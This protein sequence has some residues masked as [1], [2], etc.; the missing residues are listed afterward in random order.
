MMTARELHLLCGNWDKSPEGFAT[1]VNACL[2][3]FGMSQREL[4]DEFEVAESTLSR[5]ANGVTSPHPGVRKL[6]V[7]S[8]GKRAQR[9]SRNRFGAESVPAPMVAKG[10]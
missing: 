8:I 2:G 9:A 4:A 1:I 6:V 7:T 3:L 10:H 5:W